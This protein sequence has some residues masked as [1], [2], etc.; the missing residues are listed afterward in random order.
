MFSD[1]IKGGEIVHYHVPER[2]FRQFEYEQRITQSP[3]VIPNASI[4]TID[5]C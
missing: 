4:I 5:N 2:V 1:W 3:N